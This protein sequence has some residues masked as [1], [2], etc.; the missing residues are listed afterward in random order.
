MPT[1]WLPLLLQTSDPLFPTGAY[2]HSLG[3]E[4]M[5]RLRQVRDEATL[6]AFLQGQITPALEQLE[7][8]L[9]NQAHDAA[10]AGN[11][12]ALVALNAELDAW[13]LAQELREASLQIGTRR[14]QMLLKLSDTPLLRDFASATGGAAHHLTVYA[15]QGAA[16]PAD[17]VLTAYAYQT[18]AGHC[19]AALKLI[20]IGQE[21]CQRVLHTLLKGCP[22]MVN[23]AL[24]TAAGEVSSFNPLLEIA[25]M[26][27]QRAFERLFIS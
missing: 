8:P 15:V 19:S 13:K 12:A 26:R 5:V 25:A 3:L 22:A 6:T 10:L 4:E 7:L 2:A 23:T 20:R 11:V 14:L 21:G 1:A 16:M 27:H 17:A 9:L 18:Y 24:A